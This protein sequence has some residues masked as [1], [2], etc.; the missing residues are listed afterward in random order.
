MKLPAEKFIIFW[1]KLFGEN[2]SQPIIAMPTMFSFLALLCGASALVVSP[3][4]MPL[5]G[6]S[7]TS[8]APP[9]AA[10]MSLLHSRRAVLAGA[11]AAAAPLA[12]S[13]TSALQADEKTLAD[14]EKEVKIIDGSIKAERSAAFKDELAISR[15]N[16]EVLE[17]FKKGDKARAK[18]LEAEL[19]TLTARYES[20]EQVVK[21][22][23]TKEAEEEAAEKAQLAK[24]GADKA[25]DA[26]KEKI[27]LA[28]AQKSMLA[29]IKK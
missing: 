17:A 14:E 20:E 5:L 3:A 25:A 9:A 4:S 21:S 27:E 24:I 11:L 19:K 13:A 2:R 29:N 1:C 16:D 23:L 28:E 15:K 10:H 26:A 22:L 12:A 6:S 7:V 18:D 8:S